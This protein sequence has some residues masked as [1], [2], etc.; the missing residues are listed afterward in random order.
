[1]QYFA[2]SIIQRKLTHPPLPKKKQTIIFNRFYLVMVQVCFSSKITI[3]DF[4]LVL[5]RYSKE[6]I[7]KVLAS[8]VHVIAIIELFV[9]GLSIFKTSAPGLLKMK[10]ITLV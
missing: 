7:G 6:E 3:R 10:I 2:E 1:M 5:K 4:N 8:Q 9:D